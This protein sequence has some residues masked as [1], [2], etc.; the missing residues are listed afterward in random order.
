MS[1]EG[2]GNRQGKSDLRWMRKRERNQEIG[3][4]ESKE[5]GIQGSKH[6]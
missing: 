5:S 6:A 1:N 2:R 3:M 4:Y